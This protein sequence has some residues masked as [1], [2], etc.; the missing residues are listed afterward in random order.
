MGKAYRGG[1][2]YAD[3]NGRQKAPDLQKT[4]IKNPQWQDLHYHTQKSAF[5]FDKFSEYQHR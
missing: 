5:D 1:A 2:K 3:R 4:E